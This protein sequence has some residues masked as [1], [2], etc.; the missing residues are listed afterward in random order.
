MKSQLLHHLQLYWTKNYD[1]DLGR[2]ISYVASFHNKPIE[3][4]T[5]TEVIDYIAVELRL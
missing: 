1:V 4:I 2:L 3:D 5:D